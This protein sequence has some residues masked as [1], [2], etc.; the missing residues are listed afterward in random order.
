M[1]INAC[2]LVL[3]ALLHFS[4]IRLCHTKCARLKTRALSALSHTLREKQEK[5]SQTLPCEVVVLVPFLMFEGLRAQFA[6]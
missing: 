6:A 5:M 4:S 3:Q 1:H 2:T